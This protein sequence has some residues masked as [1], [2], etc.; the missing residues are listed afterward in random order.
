MN[1]I[2]SILTIVFNP[3]HNPKFGF[4]KRPEVP[5]ERF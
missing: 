5:E 2:Y 1:R 4:V 3:A